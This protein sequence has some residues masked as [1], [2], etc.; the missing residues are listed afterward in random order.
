M[1]PYEF[2]NDKCLSY[3]ANLHS[4]I[5]IEKIFKDTLPKCTDCETV[6]KPDVV[7]FGENLPARFFDCMGNDFPDCD[8][9]IIMGTSLVVQPFATL[10][11]R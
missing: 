9:L 11:D 8:L 5:L 10:V 3:F 4:L 2:M 6:I 1:N 7:F